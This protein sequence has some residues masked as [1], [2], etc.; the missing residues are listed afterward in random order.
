MSDQKTVKPEVGMGAT[1]R[2]YSQSYAYTIIAISA[3]GKTITLQ[4]DKTTL[5][6]KDELEFQPG[7]FAAHCS[8]Q[9]CQRYS[10]ERDPEGGVRKASLRKRDGRFHMK[11]FGDRSG[12][13]D[14]DVR[15]EF[16]DYNF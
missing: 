12:R 16:Y 10:Y 5:L 1:E 6:N 11:G 8:N 13:V 14:L 3:S 7:G 4:R 2:G 9:W 15:D